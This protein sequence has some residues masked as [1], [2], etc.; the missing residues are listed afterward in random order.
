MTDI[1]FQQYSDKLMTQMPKGVFMA[2]KANGE[3]NLMTIGWGH[4][5]IAWGKPVFNVMVRYSRHTYKLLQE[6]DEFTI[7]VPLEKPLQKELGLCGSKSGRELNKFEATGLTPLPGKKVAAPVIEECD[8]FYECKIIYRQ[9][10][11]P[12]AI[13]SD[14]QER[15][16][17]NFDYHVFFCGEIVASYIKE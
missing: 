3:D 9:A 16:Y 6:T 8:L 17:K 13:P 5:G 4:L 1:E 7:S 2:V 11:E 14:I 12:T 10:M 15:Y